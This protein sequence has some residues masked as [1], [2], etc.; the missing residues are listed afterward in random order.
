MT[1][2]Q[3]AARFVRDVRAALKTD[4]D[5]RLEVF[6]SFAASIGD[7]RKKPRVRNKKPAHVQCP[8]A[9]CKNQGVKKFGLFCSEHNAKLTAKEKKALKAKR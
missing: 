3:L 6:R 1:P 8:V 9:N 4:P 2:D 5:F 7:R